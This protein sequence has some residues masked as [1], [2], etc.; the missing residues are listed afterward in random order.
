MQYSI[1]LRRIAFIPYGSFNTGDTASFQGHLPH[2]K[3]PDFAAAYC[4]KLRNRQG[5]IHTVF[6]NNR[7][8][9]KIAYYMIIAFIR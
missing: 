5:L 7:V 8:K 1:Q 2:P 3:S 4:W 6:R 9:H